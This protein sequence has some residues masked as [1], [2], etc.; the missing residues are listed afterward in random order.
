MSDGPE[1]LAEEAANV[2][3]LRFLL[4]EKDGEVDQLEETGGRVGISPAASTSLA[5]EVIVDDDAAEAGSST[6]SEY[7][8]TLGGD[9]DLNRASSSGEGEDEDEE[10]E[11]Q[12][13]LDDNDD[14]FDVEIRAEK[15]DPFPDRDSFPA[16]PGVTEGFA[17]WKQALEEEC[18]ALLKGSIAGPLAFNR[19]F[20]VAHGIY[21]CL[22]ATPT[23]P[24]SP[25]ASF[26]RKLFFDNAAAIAVRYATS[27]PKGESHSQRIR[28]ENEA[29]FK[30]TSWRALMRR[31]SLVFALQQVSERHA[32]FI[33]FADSVAHRSSAR[34]TEHLAAGSTPVRGYTIARATADH[35]AGMVISSSIGSRQVVSHRPSGQT[36]FPDPK[37]S[38]NPHGSSRDW[39]RALISPWLG[40]GH[41]DFAP[42]GSTACWHYRGG[43]SLILPPNDRTPAFYGVDINTRLTVSVH[44]PRR[45]YTHIFTR[46]IDRVQHDPCLVIHFV[47]YY[48]DNL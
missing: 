6:D 4:Y 38:S 20:P 45:G 10:E 18:E 36:P 9:R 28:A 8:L 19:L 33:A 2:A 40:L 48:H 39:L 44:A 26:G 30:A 5:D 46:D 35:I 11:Y 32:W 15:H 47:L 34:I 22:V 27:N 7:L 42:D 13:L 29:V 1:N 43:S 21:N 14:D 3:H 24:I 37:F 12:E 41:R 17:T 25:S 16:R 31:F 23:A